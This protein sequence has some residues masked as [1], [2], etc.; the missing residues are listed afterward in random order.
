MQWTRST[1]QLQLIT[2][3]IGRDVPHTGQSGA[4]KPLVCRCS[5]PTKY[6][7]RTW[8]FHGV[9]LQANAEIVMR[10][11]LDICDKNCHTNNLL[12]RFFGNLKYALLGR[13]TQYSLAELMQKLVEEVVPAYVD[14]RCYMLV[15]RAGTS[16]LAAYQ[17]R[18]EEAVQSLLATPGAIFP[19]TTSGAAP[20]QAIVSHGDVAHTTVLG[21][22]SCSCGYAG[23]HAS[24][25]AMLTTLHF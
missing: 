8:A 13:K 16:T 20:G 5:M 14:R 6:R 17:L 11:R 21:D 24:S 22:L 12:E 4:G 7:P 1:Q 15:G 2:E 3:P 23:V 10:C 9:T 25:P 19:S 18:R